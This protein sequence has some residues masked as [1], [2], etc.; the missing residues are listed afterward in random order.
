MVGNLECRIKFYREK[1]P[2][3]FFYTIEYSYP[4]TNSALPDQT[5]GR[6]NSFKHRY[7]CFKFCGR[8]GTCGIISIDYRGTR[9]SGTSTA[10]LLAVNILSLESYRQRPIFQNPFFHK[11]VFFSKIFF[12]KPPSKI[13][14]VCL[15]SEYM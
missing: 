8:S 6:S 11:T 14:E 9:T 5:L 13:V 15:N 12:G 4:S 10:A 7:C 1:K 3:H 2:R